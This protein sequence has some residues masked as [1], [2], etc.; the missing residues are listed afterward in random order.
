M[1][2]VDIAKVMVFYSLSQLVEVLESGNESSVNIENLSVGVYFVRVMNNEGNA[3]T[4]KVSV[5]R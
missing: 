3:T 2:G 1:K 5:V 4:K